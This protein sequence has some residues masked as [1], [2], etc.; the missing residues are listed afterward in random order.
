MTVCAAYALAPGVLVE[1]LG[2]GCAAYSATAGSSHVLNAS[3]AA[4]LDILG[5]HPVMS[6]AQVAQEVAAETGLPAEEAQALLQAV[7]VDLVAAGLV[8]EVASAVCADCA[9]VD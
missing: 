5:E 9:D 2:E 8:R 6:S 7:W 3:A 1:T 4:V